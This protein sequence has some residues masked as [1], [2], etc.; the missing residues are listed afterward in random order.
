[1]PV[2]WSVGC[3]WLVGSA[4]PPL[5]YATSPGSGSADLVR[6]LLDDGRPGTK[7]AS[8]RPVA[9]QIAGGVGSGLP[10]DQPGP[11]DQ[12]REA[13]LT[14]T[15]WGHRVVGL[16]PWRRR[17]GWPDSP[18]RWR[19]PPAACRGPATRRHRRGQRGQAAPARPPT[20]ARPAAGDRA[21]PAD[22]AVL[23]AA[24]R[25]VGCR[26]QPAGPIDMPGAGPPRRLADCG[27][28]GGRPDH[29]PGPLPSTAK[30]VG[31][32][33]AARCWSASAI[34]ASKAANKVRSRSMMV[35]AIGAWSVGMATVA[36]ATSR[37]ATG[38]RTCTL[39]RRRP[40]ESRP[41]RAR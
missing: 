6:V 24:S 37:S 32:S 18:W 4:G 12:E 23:A 28:I 2:C 39:G 9:R 21:F 10:A 17:C 26:A 8:A 16:G 3:G 41:P 38:A 19:S 25:G 11:P 7:P 14:S 27:P 20:T 31:G 34:W 13:G 40:A 36:A 1:M 29:P 15:G 35:R 5:T 30:G 33:R 22:G